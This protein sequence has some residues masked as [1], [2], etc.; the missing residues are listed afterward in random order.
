MTCRISYQ[1]IC[2]RCQCEGPVSEVG[3]TEARMLA[4]AV[5]WLVGKFRHPELC[6]LCRQE[7]GQ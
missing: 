3:S 7:T 4:T 5:G 1:V 6:T 2:D